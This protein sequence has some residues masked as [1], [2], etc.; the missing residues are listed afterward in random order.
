M[1]PMLRPWLP[2]K[3]TV[4][5]PPAGIVVPHSVPLRLKRVRPLPRSLVFTTAPQASPLMVCGL[6]KLMLQPCSASALVLV[7]V[8]SAVKPFHQ[9][10]PPTLTNNSPGAEAAGSPAGAVGSIS[11][12]CGA[13]R[14]TMLWK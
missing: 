6:S 7:S 14:L 12:G 9:R 4:T 13:E 8:S 10:L 3:P 2:L 5:E 11:S 1:L